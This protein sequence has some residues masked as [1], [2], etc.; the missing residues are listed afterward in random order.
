MLCEQRHVN[1]VML[2]RN[3]M[4]CHNP[5]ISTFQSPD[6][7]TW[8]EYYIV[9][10]GDKNYKIYCIM[11]LTI[12]K[13]TITRYFVLNL[14]IIIFNEVTQNINEPNRKDERDNTSNNQNN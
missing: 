13:R 5:N 6:R 4:P 11:V 9:V 14:Q 12:N 7:N 3:Y 2:E 10:W 1:T 8:H